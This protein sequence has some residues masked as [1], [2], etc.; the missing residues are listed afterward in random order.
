M[1]SGTLPLSIQV[2]SDIFAT[3]VP[4]RVRYEHVKLGLDISTHSA[5]D[6]PMPL[7]RHLDLDPTGENTV[8]ITIHDVPLLRTV[9]LTGIIVSRVNL[10]WEQLTSLTLKLVLPGECVPIL[11]QSPNLVHCTLHLWTRSQVINHLG[12]EITLPRLDSLVLKMSH[13]AVVT[14]FLPTLI[15]P[16]L[17]SLNCSEQV[18]ESNL[19]DSLKS[20]I[21]K[22]GCQMGHVRVTGISRVSS[23]LNSFRD[24]F[25]SIR[26]F[27]FAGP[28]DTTDDEASDDEGNSSDAS[29]DKSSSDSE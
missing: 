6:G 22:S 7:L 9:I 8:G 20:F 15:V 12:P 24:A 28:D 23:E 10:P 19:V 18:L 29:D 14:G 26:N 25:P 4:H 5:I 1:R 13:G 16:A 2:D 21:S 11:Q 27:V 3:F 17:R